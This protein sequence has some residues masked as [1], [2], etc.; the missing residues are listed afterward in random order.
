MAERRTRRSTRG[1]FPEAGANPQPQARRRSSRRNGGLCRRGA[2]RC[3]TRENLHPPSGEER[4][5]DKPIRYDEDPEHQGSRDQRRARCMAPDG[6]FQ[7]AVA[8]HSLY[9]YATDT[10]RHSATGEGGRSFGG[11]WHVLKAASSS[12]G[13]STMPVTTT[14][15]ATPVPHP[16]AVLLMTHERQVDGGCESAAARDVSDA[17][18]PRL[19]CRYLQHSF[20]VGGRQIA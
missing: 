8:G 2:R 4:Q 14:T 15:A 5:S 19:P 17:W 9:R 16:S 13:G 18:P 20:R 3:G 10:H 6:F 12:S 7:V 1:Q 11:T